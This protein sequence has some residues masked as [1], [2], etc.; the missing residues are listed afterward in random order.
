[1]S[2]IYT[3]C[4]ETTS[5]KESKMFSAPFM[6]RIK[7]II[8]PDAPIKTRRIEYPAAIIIDDGKLHEVV[9]HGRSPVRRL[10]F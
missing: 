1:M 4:K 6:T 2:K 9:I 7:N 5:K 8:C 10:I 3:S